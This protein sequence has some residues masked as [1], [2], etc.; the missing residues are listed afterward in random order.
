MQHTITVRNNWTIGEVSD[1]YHLPVLE[2]IYRAATVHRAFHD[3]QEVQVCTLLSIKTGGCPEDCAYCSQSARYHTN[4]KAHKLLSVEEVVEKAKEAKA[5]G[6][7]RFCMGAAWREVRENRDFERVLEMVKE[8]SN[9]GLEVCCTLGMLTHEQALKLKE[10][11]LY[12]YNH[13][14]DTSEKFYGEII[15]T[16]TYEDRLNTLKNVQKA[17]I[18]VC[19]GG[20]IGL[21]ETTQDRI[22]MLHT[23][24]T[25]PMHPE[26]VPINALVPIEGT[27]LEN[28]P[29]VSV[30]DMVRMIATARILMPKAMI[31]L[32]AGRLEMTVEEQA[33]CFLAGANSIFSGDKL[34]TT[35][36]PEAEQD[37]KLF[38]LLNLKPR[39]A[40]KEQTPNFIESL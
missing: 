15:S 8:V 25:L 36:N 37:T 2:L 16:R 1:I 22:N 17:N 32:S 29:R 19:C 28:A 7:T 34:L 13:N 38:Q 30:W 20:I 9:L 35:P 11:G 18:S 23:L 31:R 24:A 33:L 40:F 26:S 21:G 10:A 3:P 39:K 6:S 5:A 27:P 4:V 12:A 14:L